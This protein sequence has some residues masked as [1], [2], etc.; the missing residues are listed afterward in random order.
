MDSVKTTRTEAFFSRQTYRRL[1]DGSL[2]VFV[3]MKQKGGELT[4]AE[5]VFRSYEGGTMVH[6]FRSVLSGL[7]LDKRHI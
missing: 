3:A 5:F 4:E 1:E 7:I 6:D 2:Q